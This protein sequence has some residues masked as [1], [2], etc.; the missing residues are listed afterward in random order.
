MIAAGGHVIVGSHPDVDQAPL[1]ELLQREDLAH[2][3]F[4]TVKDVVERCRQVLT[5]GKIRT[6]GCDKDTAVLL[7]SNTP[8][9]DLLVE[10]WRPGEASPTLETVQLTG[11]P[12]AVGGRSGTG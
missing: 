9:A 8:I 7:Q 4:A 2:V 6:V 11:V 5:P 1:V 3:W 12:R 10:V